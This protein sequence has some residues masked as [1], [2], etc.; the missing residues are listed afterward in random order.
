MTLRNSSPICLALLAIALTGCGNKDLN[1]GKAAE[2]INAHKPFHTDLADVPGSAPY[3]CATVKDIYWTELSEAGLLSFSDLRIP[4]PKLPSYLAYGNKPSDYCI[5]KPTAK[6]HGHYQEEGKPPLMWKWFV[7][8][9][10][11]TDVTN[12]MLLDPNTAVVTFAYDT[13]RTDLPKSLILVT[14]QHVGKA[15]IRRTEGVW[16]V[17][18]T[19][20]PGGEQ[21]Q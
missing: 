17:V 19:N 4:A 20:P 21:P 14:N 16:H 9:R 1:P 7:G 5:A 3:T 2:L 10:T 13:Q 8:T 18:G 12:I 15:D 11:V 6:A